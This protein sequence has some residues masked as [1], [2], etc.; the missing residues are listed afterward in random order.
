MPKVF[1]ARNLTADTSKRD[2]DIDKITEIS[3]LSNDNSSLANANNENYLNNGAATL[4][5]ENPELKIIEGKLQ[6]REKIG[7]E[8]GEGTSLRLFDE[9]KAT[10]GSPTALAFTVDFGDNKEIDTARYQNLFRRYNA[11][12]RRNLSAFKVIKKMQRY[13]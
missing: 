6:E 3:R 10:S 9:S 4:S 12:H 8:E 5:E 2:D 13:R 7:I 1:D 11:R